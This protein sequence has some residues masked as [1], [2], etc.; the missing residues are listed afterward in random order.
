MDFQPAHS[1]PFL[2]Q[3]PAD[4]WFLDAMALQSQNPLLLVIT[5]K[6]FRNTK[7]MHETDAVQETRLDS[8]LTLAHKQNTVLYWRLGSTVD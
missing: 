6:Y 8:R 4:V 3:N 7:T 5:E 2:L 1:H